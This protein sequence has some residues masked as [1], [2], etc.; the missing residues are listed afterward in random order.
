VENE[1]LVVVTEPYQRSKVSLSPADQYGAGVAHQDLTEAVLKH[2]AARVLVLSAPFASSVSL[3]V[4]ALTTRAESIDELRRSHGSERVLEGSVSD[5]RYLAARLPLVYVAPGTQSLQLGQVRY[6]FGPGAFPIATII[7][8]VH[9]P[10][11][12][13]S[14]ANLLL[15][16]ERFDSIIVTSRAARRVVE[17]A[18]SEAWKFLGSRLALSNECQ[19]GV[20]LENLPLGLDEDSVLPRDK[21]QCRA[22][23][24]LP[25]DATI[26][27]YVGR[28]TEGH[29]ADL[30][31]LL[32]AFRRLTQ[33]NSSA[34][35]VI[36]G[37]LA[38]PVTLRY[39]ATWHYAITL[40][41]SYG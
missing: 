39:C 23:I 29:K 19:N 25:Q 4:R 12:L 37:S 9:W 35:L 24:D 3:S 1:D 5:I 27:L 38:H 22:T 31:P 36:A 8:S 2:S 21:A 20:R 15:L 14:F 6:A 10:N 18:L 28:L 7:H 40:P 30:E 26:I 16:Y 32:I 11:M 13:L 34:F 41:T 17:F 33:T